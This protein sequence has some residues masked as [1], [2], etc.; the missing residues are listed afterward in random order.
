[1]SQVAE[2]PRNAPLIRQAGELDRLEVLGSDVTYRLRSREAGGPSVVE[3]GAKEGVGVPR[4]THVNE[5]ETFM[6]IEGVVTFELEGHPAP[7]AVGAGGTVH[8]PRGL[9]HAFRNLGPAPARMLVMLSPGD[10]I[11]GMFE[12]LH[13]LPPGADGAAIGAICAN[14]GITFA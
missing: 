4:H 1:M 10:A 6:V 14:C 12:E 2:R 11:E 3:I 8:A 5:D 9:A 7:V 13:E